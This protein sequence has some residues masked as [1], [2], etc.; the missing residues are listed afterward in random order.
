V[1]K[2]LL[3]KRLVFVTGKG[4]VGK[5][6][7]AAA[8]GMLAAREGRKT[9][10]VEVS[11]QE[12]V[13]RAFDHDDSDF[14][15]VEL[16]PGLF[17]ISI[18]P[19]RALEEYLQIQ[20]RV[21][22]LA[23]LL[24]GS[25]MFQ[26]FAAATP[27]MSEL[28]TMGKIWEL[29]QPERR[30]RHASP[31]DLVI[32]DAPATGHGVAVMRAPRTFSDIARVGPV[33]QQG[34]TIDEYV[35]NPKRTGVLAVCAPEEMPVNETFTLRDELR[36]QMGLELGA[37]V[38]NGMYPDRFADTERATL[39]AALAGPAAAGPAA[40][41][42]LRAAL[43]EDARAAAQREQRE[44]LEEGVGLEAVELPFLFEPEIG[45][46]QFE[47]LSRVLEAAP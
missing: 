19:R 9:I 30:A 29:A 5:S 22:A 25:R 12:R 31:Y 37:V 21:K 13:A 46:A 47:R 20:V 18:S 3:E 24:S 16:V 41:A 36:R 7:V 40:R 11:H 28:L 6:T 34:R 39:E 14:A 27:G 45:R 10:L 38:L 2:K 32:V 26:Y 17:T 35:S 8:L 43:S 1:P 23:D 44:R 33:A 4:G 15:E 42:A